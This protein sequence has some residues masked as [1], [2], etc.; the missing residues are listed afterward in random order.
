MAGVAEERTQNSLEKIGEFLQGEQY[1][2][3]MKNSARYNV[4]IIRER[5]ARMP[6]LDSQTG[7]V[8]SPQ[9]HPICARQRMSVS[10]E[11]EGGLVYRYPALPWRRKRR[12]YLEAKLPGNARTTYND[13][14]DAEL[15]ALTATDVAGILGYEGQATPPPYQTPPPSY[16]TP[17]PSYQAT[18]PSYQATPVPV[19]SYFYDDDFLMEEEEGEDDDVNDDTYGDSR[20]KGAPKRPRKKQGVGRSAKGGR[21]RSDGMPRGRNTPTAD[22]PFECI[23]CGGRY[24]SKKGLSYH[25]RKRCGPVEA[26]KPMAPVTHSVVPPPPLPQSPLLSLPLQVSTLPPPPPLASPLPFASPLASLLPLAS[27]LAFPLTSE[28]LPEPPTIVAEPF[29][30][31]VPEPSPPVVAS[32]LPSSIP[33]IKNDHQFTSS[34]NADSHNHAKQ[35]INIKEVSPNPYCDFCLGDSR[36]NKKTG[37][38]ELMVSCSDCG[39]SGHP[40]CLQFTPKM[41]EAVRRYRWQCIECKCCTLCG[42]AENDDQLLFCDYCDRGCHLYCVRPPLQ[43]PPEGEWACPLCV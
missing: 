35:A 6:F 9:K 32:P 3:L 33:P 41:S 31:E 39:R 16:Q 5:K 29:K 42:S 20:R 11:N 18:P 1:L 21:P 23:K 24:K 2:S 26:R 15:T 40:T 19:E 36:H 8:Q 13:E 38:A 12:S 28:P 14:A 43:E 17:P 10:P 22:K 37:V 7:L 27:P 25:V 30:I 4:R 34:P